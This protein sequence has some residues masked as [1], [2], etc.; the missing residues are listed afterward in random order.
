MG[1]SAKEGLRT[2]I[3]RIPSI[4]LHKNQESA[5][6]RKGFAQD[7]PPQKLHS[8]GMQ[9]TPPH[10]RMFVPFHR[11][12]VSRGA[13]SAL[14]RGRATVAPRNPLSTAYRRRRKNQSVPAVR[15]SLIIGVPFSLEKDSKL[16]VLGI[17][18]LSALVWVT[19]SMSI[20]NFENPRFRTKCFSS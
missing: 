6:V 5:N 8:P 2:S 19:D 11:H 7:C 16:S 17:A 1:I 9:V 10:R 12:E 4:L 14:H 20:V 13:R 18:T 3:R 15:R